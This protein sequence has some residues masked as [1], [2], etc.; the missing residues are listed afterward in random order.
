[1]PVLMSFL[2]SITHAVR[3]VVSET[4]VLEVWKNFFDEG[5]NWREL[6]G[7]NKSIS[8][9][10]FRNLSDA[11][12]IG[13]IKSKPIKYLLETES[14]FFHKS[15]EGILELDARIHEWLTAEVFY[16]QIK[17]CLEYRTEYH[18]YHRSQK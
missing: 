6:A 15:T 4:Q 11:W 14:T 3:P 2:D 13:K 8:Y 7:K 10:E 9:Q 12:H 1:M 17:N 16:T 5:E 18:Y